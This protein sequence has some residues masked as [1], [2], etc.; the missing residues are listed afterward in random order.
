MGKNLGK[1]LSRDLWK[2]LSDSRTFLMGTAIL[3]IVL[4]HVRAHSICP[5]GALA[6]LVNDLVGMG[7]GGCDVFFFLSGFGIACSL[8]RDS[9]LRRYF[10][11]RARK[12]FPAY[13]PFILIYLLCV[14]VLRG[15]T[16][17][18]VLGNL[19]FLG[20][21][22][23]KGNQF[24]WYIQTAVAFYLF[25][26]MAYWV[27][28]N[29]QG[30]RS[31]V[32]LGAAALGLQ[33]AFFGDYLMIAITRVPIFLLGMVFG[34]RERIPWTKGWL[35]AAAVL[36]LGGLVFWRIS[37]SYLTWGNGLY[38]YPFL[39][40]TPGFC[41][42]VGAFRPCWLRV[43]WMRRIDELVCLCGKCSYEIYLVHL[44]F[45]ETLLAQKE[46]NGFWL[47][48]GVVFTALGIGYH[49][50]VAFVM[51]KFSFHSDHKE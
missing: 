4:F 25:A 32:V 26:P 23:E 43:R 38:W 49:Y 44:L 19:T 40:L 31:W 8:K 6:A 7:Y 21:W 30:W 42:L 18:E 13:Y 16:V 10:G 46:G 11:R 20:F 12:L 41:L 1:L 24:N 27:M 29:W 39:L 2:D 48:M 5:E 33:V 36:L 37:L 9:N 34:C 22:L 47:M 15:I 28:R 50:A 51:R 45:F 35:A 17:G 14:G 3:G